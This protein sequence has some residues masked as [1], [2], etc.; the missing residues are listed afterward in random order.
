MRSGVYEFKKHSPATCNTLR[1]PL[2]SL[3]MPSIVYFVLKQE[4][5]KDRG[6]HYDDTWI[7]AIDMSCKIVGVTFRYIEAVE[8]STLE[9]TRCIEHK[10]WYFEPF[11]HVEFPAYFHLDDR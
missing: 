11:L 9:V 8:K 2:L 6:Y 5:E 1:Y 3:D 4:G 7:V 10:Y